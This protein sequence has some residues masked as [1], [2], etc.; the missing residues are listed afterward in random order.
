MPAMPCQRSKQSL[1]PCLDNATL[2]LQNRTPEFM[3]ESAC[4]AGFCLPDSRE[5]SF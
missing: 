3:L 4:N 5:V 1:F 2:S